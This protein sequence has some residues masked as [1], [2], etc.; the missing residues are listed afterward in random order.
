MRNNPWLCG[1]K[2]GSNEVAFFLSLNTLSQ[3]KAYWLVP[4]IPRM[5]LSSPVSPFSHKESTNPVRGLIL[6]C[7]LKS[8]SHTHDP[9][10]SQKPHLW[11]HEALG[12]YLNTIH[13]N[14][15][16]VSN[17][18]FCENT[19]T[20]NRSFLSRTWRK[21]EWAGKVWENFRLVKIFSE[22]LEWLTHAIMQLHIPISILQNSEL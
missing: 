13:N 21:D 22:I 20:V 6:Y 18:R 14:I 12:E 11:V 5:W 8:V 15:L 10:T 19:E 16:Y 7:I 3:L 4:L 2:A 9:T 17:Y 1:Q